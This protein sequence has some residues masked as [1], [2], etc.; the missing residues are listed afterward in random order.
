MNHLSMKLK[1]FGILMLGVLLGAARAEDKKELKDQKEKVSYALGMNIGSSFK[2]QDI[3][4]DYDALI[5]G[6]KDTMDNKT[7]L[8]SEQEQRQVLNAY[9]T[10]NTA[11]REA[12]RKEQAIKNK[13]EGEKFLTENK[14]KPGVITRPSGLQVQNPH[15]RHWTHTEDQRYGYGPLPRHFDRWD[16][17]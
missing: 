12:K 1:L 7:T 5:Q 14:T 8:V 17:V 2:S 10:E 3:E 13:A 6:I 4:V 16:R 11:K 15:R 9:R